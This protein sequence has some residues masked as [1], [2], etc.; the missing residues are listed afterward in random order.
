MINVEKKFHLFPELH[1]LGKLLTKFIPLLR[2][3]DIPLMVLPTQTQL[4]RGWKTLCLF[5]VIKKLS[6][7]NK[8][9]I[10]G[11]QTGLGL[12][13]KKF[14]MMEGKGEKKKSEAS[15]SLGVARI[16]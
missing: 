14:K 7:I 1:P 9:S 5:I 4:L 11:H 10:Y 6:I 12:S 13:W 15:I 8:L 2:Q 16:L 3:F